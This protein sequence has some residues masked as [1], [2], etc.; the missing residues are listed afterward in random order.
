MSLLPFDI[1]VSIATQAAE[2]PLSVV[3][4]V[5]NTVAGVDRQTVQA[6]YTI[7]AVVDTTNKRMLQQIFGG[8]VSDGDIG[9]TPSRGDQL[10]FL[11]AFRPGD[12]RVQSF[13][14]YNGWQY[15]ILGVSDYTAQAGAQVYLGSR[16]ITQEIV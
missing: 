6:A 15:R 16:H 14:A 13:V 11:D 4:V 10:N 12:S 2:V 5:Y 1:G 7:Y 9:I 8:S 3:D